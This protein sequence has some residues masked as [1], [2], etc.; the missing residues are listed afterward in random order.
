[1]L[2]DIGS[3]PQRRPRTTEQAHIEHFICACTKLSRQD[4]PWLFEFRKAA[5]PLSMEMLGKMQPTS[6]FDEVPGY[7]CSL[8]FVI[9]ILPVISPPPSYHCRADIPNRG[10]QLER[11]SQLNLK[12]PWCDKVSSTEG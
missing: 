4:L 1:L 7:R 8:T 9:Q 12:A 10:R 2:Q 3:E 6:G 5:L 11:H